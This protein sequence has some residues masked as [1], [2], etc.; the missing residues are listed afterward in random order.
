MLHKPAPKELV[1][2]EAVLV[3]FDQLE[4]LMGFVAVHAVSADFLL[5][6]RIIN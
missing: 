4:S 1:V 5:T 3:H 6:F 2:S